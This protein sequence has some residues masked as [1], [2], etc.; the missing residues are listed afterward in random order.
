MVLKEQCQTQFTVSILANCSHT[1]KMTTSEGEKLKWNLGREARQLNSDY[2]G[3][4]WGFWEALKALIPNNFP[5]MGK[6]LCMLC[7]SIEHYFVCDE[8]RGTALNTPQQDS[9]ILLRGGYTEQ[10]QQ[11]PEPFLC[12]AKHLCKS[13]WSDSSY[14]C[15][16]KWNLPSLFRQQW[17]LCSTM[18]CLGDAPTLELQSAAICDLHR[19]AWPASQGSDSAPQGWLE[20]WRTSP[21]RKKK[22]KIEEKPLFC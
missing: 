20:G 14:L 19:Y 16:D 13:T 1:S 6:R 9:G 8:R 2:Q 17:L 12:S 4:W 3:K 11:K 5:F 15:W 21:T 22:K 7:G 18:S 10:A